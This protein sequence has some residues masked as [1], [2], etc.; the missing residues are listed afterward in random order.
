MKNINDKI[1]KILYNEDITYAYNNNK[2]ICNSFKKMTTG[3]NIFQ[4]KIKQFQ[5][6]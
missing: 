5:I 3:M 1:I 2:F 4:K 6:E